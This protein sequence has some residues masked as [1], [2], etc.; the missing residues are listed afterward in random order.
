[1][2]CNSIY[3]CGRISRRKFFFQA[4]AGFVGTALGALWAEEGRI[5]ETRLLAPLTPR[6]R[7]VI[8]LFLCGGGR[9]LHTFDPK[10]DK[11]GG[12]AIEG[13]WFRDKPAES[14]GDG[15]PH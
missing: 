13:G 10:D 2:N 14:G 9:H 6:A 7:A 11:M 8:F 1:M 3:P 4:G 15:V 12:K 5:P